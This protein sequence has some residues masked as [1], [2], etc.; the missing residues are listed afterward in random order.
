MAPVRKFLHVSKISP[1]ETL[2]QAL[3]AHLVL[4]MHVGKLV[5]EI[6]REDDRVRVPDTQF[7]APKQMAL[8]KCAALAEACFEAS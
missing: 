3:P 2:N 6:P 1:C 8:C 4:L 7:H 5:T